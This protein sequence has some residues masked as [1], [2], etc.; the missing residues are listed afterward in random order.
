MRSNSMTV[1]SVTFSR[2]LNWSISAAGRR[3]V[4]VDGLF[5][6]LL[7]PFRTQP[8]KSRDRRLVF[9]PK[10]GSLVLNYL[11]RKSV[12]VSSLRFNT[13]FSE[14]PAQFVDQNMNVGPVHV[15][16]AYVPDPIKYVCPWNH[17][18]FSLDQKPE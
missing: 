12:A 11:H 17:F 1:F 14:D 16:R 6:H 7:Q 13:A 15:L 9:L 8:V 4:L 3:P 5:Y 18:P 2:L 10:R